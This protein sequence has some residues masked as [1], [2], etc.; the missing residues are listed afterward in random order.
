MNTFR[1]DLRHAVRRLRNT[2][3]FTFAAV[4][5]L[6]L[7]IG[8]SVMMYCTVN[9]VLLRGLPFPDADRAVMILADNPAQNV[10]HAQLT[11]AEAEQLARGTTGFDALGFFEWS[12]VTMLDNGHP[13]EISAQLVGAGFFEALGVKPVLGRTPNADDI[14]IGRP[15]A[16]L[17][18]AEWQRSFGGDPQVIGRRLDLIGDAPLEVIGVMPPEMA[19]FAGDTGL[20]SPLQERVLPQDGARRLDQR[21]LQMVGRL[22]AGVSLEQANAALEAQTF[23]LR[24]AH[25]LAATQAEWRL[26]AHPL[27]D[28]LVGDARAALWGALALAVMVLLIACANV[29]ILVDARQAARRRELAVMQAIGASASRLRR[30]L[31]LELLLVAVISV[32]LGIAL[33][34]GGI[35]VLRELA[36]GSVPR[37]DG[38]VMDWRV[39]GVA[40]LLGLA[41]PFAAALNGSLR[42]RAAPSE[43]IRAGGKGVIGA[44]A[45]RRALPAFAMALSTLSLVIA[46]GLGAG[47]WRLQHVDP[48]FT[49]HGIHA[50]QLFRESMSVDS[51]AAGPAEWTQ[52]AERVQERLAA[53]PGTQAVTL[54]SVA[55][56]SR[57]G[58]ASVD[59]QALGKTDDE[60]PVQA[61]IRRV[62]P[63]YRRLLD[64]P[65][66]AGRDFDEGDRAGT[67]S[68]AL[69][70]RTLARRL[71][72]DASP[73]GRSI[74]LPLA[75]SG[76]AT[77]RIV[78]V[79]DDIR[80]DGLRNDPAPEVL[81][82]FAQHPRVAMTF[83]LRTRTDLPGVEA[84]MAEALW[85]VAP[86]QSITRSFALSA[87]LA[88]ELR[89]ARFFARITA[90]FAVAALLLA[91]LGAYAVASLQQR[92]R[93]GEFGLR[94][95]IGARPRALAW[96]VLRESVVASA[97]G[98]GAGL[99]AAAAML[100]LVDP[101]R[102]GVDSVAPPLAIAA[103][104]GLMAA[105][106]VA[107]ALLPAWRAA[108]VPPMEALRNE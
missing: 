75:R 27:L 77:C 92:R 82:A 24:Q 37:I 17:S 5:M 47:L 14:R 31:L 30:G 88:E 80:N 94:L 74:N 34:Q 69:I 59:V 39:F 35:D 25:G 61:A 40:A 2:P 63:G 84:Q 6:A 96:A 4:V 10:S 107:A 99:A 72:G 78:G 97:A 46:L 81:V 76:R 106:A 32:A 54:T 64:I 28:L 29:A 42:Q 49:S 18:H 103:G 98:V 44:H 83:L 62:S 67:E 95:A 60:V 38:I 68:V 102:I 3:G 23:A 13:R 20:W 101:G 19:A 89:A 86:R 85:N 8:L 1:P 79:V 53:L 26:R 52:F 33:A 58:A 48:G 87:D 57:I 91:M 45:P 36:R 22:H 70:S 41:A 71:F 108:R 66:L 93:I 100:R 16:V 55:P 105:A 73:L 104:V 12:G 7:G 50:L 90:S 21:I 9:G 11:A 15:L 65:L 51:G 56:L 43:A